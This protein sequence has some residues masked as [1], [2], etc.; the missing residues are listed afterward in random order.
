MTALL[1]TKLLMELMSQVA[2][3]LVVAIG[4]QGAMM[5]T[6]AGLLVRGLR[7]EPVPDNVVCVATLL[8]AL[9][10]IAGAR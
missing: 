5:A 9:M 8:L 2:V 7:R 1:R 6:L 4:W 10:L 3:D